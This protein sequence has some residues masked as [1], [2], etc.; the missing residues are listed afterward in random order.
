MWMSYYVLLKEQ[1]G[2]T[3]RPVWQPGLNKANNVHTEIRERCE[4]KFGQFYKLG[5]G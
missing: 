1:R 5:L 4:V 2:F 3:K